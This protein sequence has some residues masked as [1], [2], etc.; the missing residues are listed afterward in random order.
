M[1]LKSIEGSRDAPPALALEII[2]ECLGD[3]GRGD[4]DALY[5]LGI[6][7]STG[8]HGVPC[9]MIE[10]HKW[11]NLAAAQGHE[12]SSWCRADI[13]DEMTARDIAE[14]QRRA[15]EWLSAGRRAA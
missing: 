14:A 7:Y 6:M 9:D 8:S 13:A 2:A 1:Q 15:R 10:A 4:I 11:F 3:A 12:P 5:N